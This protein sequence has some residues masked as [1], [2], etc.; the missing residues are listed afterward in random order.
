M[1]KPET[2][3]QADDASAESIKTWRQRLIQGVFRSA[4]VAGGLAIAVASYTA[5]SNGEL[6]R[7]PIYLGAY[8]SV[9]L[10]AFWRRAPFALQAGT[11]LG[12][13]YVL[14]IFQ[15]VSSGLGRSP[16]LYPLAFAALAVIFFGRRIGVLA[17]ILG[18]LTLAALGWA[19]STGILAVPAE[20]RVSEADPVTWLNNGIA[21]VMLGILLVSS[22]S[23]LLQHLVT[24]LTQS[25]RLAQELEEERAGLERTVEE[26]TGAL[27]RHA[28]DLETTTTIA[29]DA[30]SELDLQD[31]L[32]HTVALVSER[33]GLYHTGIFLTDPNGEWVELRAASGEGGQRMLAR[34][35]RLRVGEGI[36]GRVTE[37]GEHRVASD[38]GEDAVHFGN[39]DLP[40]TRSEAA[41]PLRVRGETIGVLDVQS[42][43]SNA[44][45]AEDVAVLQTLADQVAVAIQNARLFQQVEESVEAERRAYGELSRDA[46]QSLLS[47]YPDLGFFSDERETVPSG[48]LWR[49]EMSAA[50]RTGEIA[51]GGDGARLA[52]PIKVRDQVIGVI[53]GRKPDGTEWAAE[54]IELL[55]ALTDQL[56]VALEGA[57]LYRD[58]Q[59]RETR[60]RLIGN[61]ATRI[62]ESLDMETMLRTAVDVMRT[63]LDLPEVVVHLATQT[64]DQE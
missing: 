58:A 37:R 41:L 27:A 17:L 63:Q 51:P 22:Q 11:L 44:F 56:N 19:F 45:S 59:S 3:I 29:R 46:W 4:I 15:M 61:V 47:A 38:V 52:I 54:E 16:L 60:E 20:G 7:I 28:R 6:W 42:A 13:L 12:V 34:G 9:A 57:R 53:D 39:P 62:R 55:Q 2:I 64:K 35:H 31:L 25:R 26:R 5:Y 14:G 33:F 43:E 32:S 23:Y 24:A 21:F 48:D 1:D 50:L 36:V 49:P 30:A 18:V 8:V 10:I 40:A